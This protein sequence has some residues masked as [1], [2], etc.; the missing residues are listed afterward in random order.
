M[1]SNYEVGRFLG[2]GSFATVHLARDK[3]N[4]QS[5]VSSHPNIVSLLESFSY[6]NEITGNNMMGILL[7]YC[8]WGDL[9]GYFKRVREEKQQLQRQYHQQHQHFH[10][11]TGIGS[12]GARK[13]DVGM[14]TGGGDV[15]LFLQTHEIR[16]ALSQILCGLSYLHS[17]GVVHRDIKAPNILLS[18]IVQT[19][20]NKLTMQRKKEAFT[21]LD[22]QLKIGDFGLAV[23]MSEEDDW[24]EAQHT[25]CGTPCCLAPEV[26]CQFLSPPPPP[27][28]PTTTTTTTTTTMTMNG[29]RTNKSSGVM[30]NKLSE[31]DDS[32]IEGMDDA[33][34]HL[35]AQQTMEKHA[36]YGQ[37]ADLWATGCLLYT[38]MVGRNPF[39]LS[40]PP[41][42]TTGSAV[43]SPMVEKRQR[44]QQIVERVVRGDWSVPSNVTIED[45]SLQLLLEQL[46]DGLPRKRGTARGILNLHPFF[47]DAAT[48]TATSFN[49]TTAA[50][51]TNSVANAG[52][53][54]MSI[55]IMDSWDLTDNAQ[56]VQD[57]SATKLSW[58]RKF[59][60][61]KF[62][63][64]APQTNEKQQHRYASS[65]SSSPSTARRQDKEN[66]CNIYHVR[67]EYITDQPQRCIS[68]DYS[69]LDPS[70]ASSF[71]AT[72]DE[73]SLQSEK[74]E[75][76]IYE[77]RGIVQ[78]NTD[79]R[80]IV[81]ER[82]QDSS[83]TSLRRVLTSM[84]DMKKIESEL[85]SITNLT[86]D[87]PSINVG[88]KA[89]DD[90]SQYTPSIC[91]KSLYRLPQA[92]YK[93]EE[94]QRNGTF[95][96]EYIIYFLGNEGIVIQQES[97][98]GGL[99]MHVTSDGLGILW[100]KLKPNSN[101]STIVPQNDEPSAL[102]MEA[103]SR[104]PINISK[105]SLSSL[106]AL[107]CRDIISLYES[108]EHAVHR[109]K[110]QTPKVTVLLF[111]TNEGQTSQLSD[112]FVKT[113]LME[114]DPVGDI[115]TEFNDETIIRLSSADGN[116]TVKGK[117]RT[118][119]FNIDPN[120]FFAELRADRTRSPSC[121][122]TMPQFLTPSQMFVHHLCIFIESARECLMFE[123]RQCG[124]DAYPAVRKLEM[125]GWQQNEWVVKSSSILS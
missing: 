79:Q 104:V 17:R 95:S 103:F 121:Q 92:K 124:N 61:S 43:V 90:Q 8:P 40:L 22:C 98:I 78:W 28:P 122:R 41:R 2:K 59:T 64:S 19:P 96:N 66:A 100:G 50:T 70:P 108:L 14:G 80:P 86:A 69:S 37:P 18:P 68:E 87:E 111:T 82:P 93:W 99:W 110:L 27:P 54:S 35:T 75:L 81:R 6:T 49:T 84:E 117:D 20:S 29:T 45:S 71:T 73:A 16:H 72:S 32:F 83:F 24:Y 94:P 65:R 116:I 51:A 48:V 38:M 114:N 67:N 77:R 57:G 109:V 42:T 63:A 5:S 125:H 4:V 15:S 9:Q 91:M 13:T 97:V 34:F 52:T 60:S 118:T 11:S 85:G 102:Y 30:D 112:Y 113:M 36:G 58:G 31:L 7:E 119:R 88:T 39:A 120:R 123:S 12:G 23:Q 55:P 101:R 47:Q 115:Q 74:N 106:L 10:H 25:F 53:A 107:Q 46:L 33:S 89:I 1:A 62:L 105:H 44:I 76:P 21:L 3:I 56:N 26:V